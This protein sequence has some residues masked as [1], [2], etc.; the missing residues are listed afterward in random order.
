MF[1]K[2]VFPFVIYIKAVI[3][4]NVKDILLAYFQGQLNEEEKTSVEK[5]IN[6]SPENQQTANDI[7]EICQYTDTLYAMKKTDEYGALRTVNKRIGKMYMSK[8]MLRI[9]RCAAVIS[10]PLLIATVWLAYQQVRQDVEYLTVT[11]N[12][13]VVTTVTLPDSSKV[14]LNSGSCL[15][16]PSEFRDDDRTV[17]LDGEAYFDVSKDARHPFVVKT[18]NNTEEIVLGTHFNV[19]AYESDQFIRTTL[20][21]GSVVF[22]KTETNGRK[23]EAKLLPGEAAVFNNKSGNLQKIKAE[24]DVAISWKD[25]ILIFRRTSARDVL[26]ALT[27]RYGVDFIVTNKKCYDNSFTGKIVNQRLDKVLE[28]LTMTSDMRFRYMRNKDINEKDIRIEVY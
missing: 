19:E 3:M 15:R 12:P 17:Y 25:N 28:Y 24:V 9:E 6:E 7:R 22:R 26:K 8:V 13:G 21:E 4:E 27:K 23:K 10:I 11:T 16:Y 18:H 20:E 1:R 5:R 2:K 14:T